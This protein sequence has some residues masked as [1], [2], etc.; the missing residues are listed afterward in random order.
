MGHETIWN[1][2]LDLNLV[3]LKL[4]GMLRNIVGNET[5]SDKKLLNSR[6]I[7]GRKASWLGCLKDRIVF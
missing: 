6:P 7:M 4:P 1:T 3:A 2:D 5:G